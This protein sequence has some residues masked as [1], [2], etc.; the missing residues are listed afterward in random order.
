MNAVWQLVGIL[1][2]VGFIGASVEMS[3]V[4]P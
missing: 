1:L 4:T 2:L 3:G